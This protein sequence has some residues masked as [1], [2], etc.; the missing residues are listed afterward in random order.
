MVNNIPMND[1][2]E[3]KMFNLSIVNAINSNIK[4]INYDAN[5]ISTAI[6]IINKYQMSYDVLLNEGSIFYVINNTNKNIVL[7]YNNKS[8]TVNT[9]ISIFICLKNELIKVL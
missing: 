1:D 9:K 6:N 3:H 7:K 8:Y 5:N 2:T 4:N